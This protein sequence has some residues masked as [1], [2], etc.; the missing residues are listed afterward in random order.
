MRKNVNKNKNKKAKVIRRETRKA[1]VTQKTMNAETFKFSEMAGESNFDLGVDFTMDNNDDEI[2]QF[3][4]GFKSRATVYK[5]CS[6]SK[7]LLEHMNILY[8]TNQK[9]FYELDK[10]ELDHLLCQ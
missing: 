5:D 6:A 9:K 3:I 7:R 8:P 2:D 1:K 4:M 10:K